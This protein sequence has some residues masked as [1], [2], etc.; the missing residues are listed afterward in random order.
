M[1][2]RDE[3]Y[4]VA[5]KI[6]EP[7]HNR[8]QANGAYFGAMIQLAYLVVLAEDA[9]Q[10]APGEEDGAGAARAHQ[11]WLLAKVRSVAVDPGVPL[12]MAEAFL[13]F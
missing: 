4:V 12:S 5:T 6:L 7:F 2:W 1:R 13:V 11:R 9:G 8:C 10:V 3:I